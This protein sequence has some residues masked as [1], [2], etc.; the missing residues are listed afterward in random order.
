MGDFSQTHLVTLDNNKMAFARFP[1]NRQKLIG[2]SAEVR[3]Q[4]GGP[5]EER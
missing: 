4:D 3:G 1:E 5:G 2:G